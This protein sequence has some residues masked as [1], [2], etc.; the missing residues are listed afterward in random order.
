MAHSKQ[1][2][3]PLLSLLHACNVHL[4]LEALFVHGVRVLQLLHQLV[5]ADILLL[6]LLL[7]LGFLL[8]AVLVSEH[9]NDAF[10]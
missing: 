8:I 9:L 4:V 7:E 3:L 2:L 10:S 6:L 5:A 1:L